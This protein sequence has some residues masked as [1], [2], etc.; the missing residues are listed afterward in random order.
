MK[1]TINTLLV[2]FINHKVTPFHAM[3]PKTNAYLKI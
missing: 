2:T 1:R 3:L